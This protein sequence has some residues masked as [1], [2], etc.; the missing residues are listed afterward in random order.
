MNERDFF[1]KKNRTFR[2]KAH[3]K[4]AAV[5]KQQKTTRKLLGI[6]IPSYFPITADA[7]IPYKFG[8]F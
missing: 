8:I 2:T 1:C 7:S 5:K 3:G 4:Q 6:N